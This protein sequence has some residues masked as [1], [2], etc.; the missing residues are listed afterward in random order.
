MKYN[1]NQIIESLENGHQINYIFFWSHKK[2]TPV[3]KSCF[4]QWYDSKFIVEGNEYYSTEQW[5]MA[6]K[7]LLFGDKEKYKQIIDNHNPK[8]IKALGR[9]VKYFN[10]R[11]WEENRYK[12]VVN[13]NLQKFSQNKELFEYIKTTNK[14]ILV[15]ASPVDMIWG[16][17]L[18]QDNPDISSPYFWK[19]LN[20]LGYALMEVRDFLCRIDEFKPLINPKLPPWLACP[21]LDR[22]SLGWSMGYGEDYMHEFTQYYASLDQSERMIYELTFPV[23][24]EWN[25][26]YQRKHERDYLQ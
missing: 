13:G 11:V 6:E 22:Y 21:E 8:K 9:Q 15:E 23:R 24:G 26:W 14:K 17:G 4:S 3:S 2:T 25:G 7:A 20:L 16:V 18:G 5:M 12:I 19:G 10:Q 1:T